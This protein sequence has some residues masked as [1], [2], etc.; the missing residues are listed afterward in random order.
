L[1]HLQ[2][3]IDNLPQDLTDEQRQKAIK[4]IKVNHDVFSVND[5]DLGLTNVLSHEINTGVNRP[6][7]ESLRRQ[8]QAY[9]S[10]I[11]EFFE[12]LLRRY[13]IEPSHLIIKRCNCTQGQ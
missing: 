10:H 1:C 5:E 6:V 13:L 8:P 2:V 4:L 7:K 9:L 3:I 11:D 12:D